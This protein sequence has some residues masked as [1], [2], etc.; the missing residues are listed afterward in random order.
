MINS[1]QSSF[2][3][4]SYRARIACSVQSSSEKTFS[5][6]GDFLLGVNM[7]SPSIL[8]KTLL[9]Q[10]INPGLVCAHMHSITH[11]KDPDIHVL[12]G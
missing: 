2:S 6:R 3:L 9:D 11:S 12:D 1:P 4:K 7:G 8:P 10:S 5:R